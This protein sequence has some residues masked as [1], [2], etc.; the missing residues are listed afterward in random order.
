MTGKWEGAGRSGMASGVGGDE[1]EEADR[2][3][4]TR[5]CWPGQG[6]W[7]FMPRSIGSHWEYLIRGQKWLN[8]FLKD[9][10][11]CSV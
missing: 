6:D 3:D 5:H 4:G 10:S 11:K 7:I 9:Y 1:V 2:P 8:S